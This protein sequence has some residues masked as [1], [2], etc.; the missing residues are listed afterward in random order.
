MFRYAEI[1]EKASPLV[2]AE[3]F[4]QESM[5]IPD[6]SMTLR[7]I[8][9]RHAQGL[10]LSDNGRVAFYDYDDPD[11]TDIDSA[12]ELENYKNMDLADQQAFRER[13]AL[14]IRSFQEALSKQK[15]D[16]AA[17][18]TRVDAMLKEHEKQQKADKK[19]Q[20][21]AEDDKK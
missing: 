14:K 6:Q 8:L 16:N 18:R 9:T 13:H 2:D 4:T 1:V 5:T 11:L 20:Q 17:Y 3:T 7:E 15:S 19:A 12:V 21:K 10:P